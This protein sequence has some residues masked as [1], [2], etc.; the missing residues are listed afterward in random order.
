MSKWQLSWAA[1][2]W[3][4][5]SDVLRPSAMLIGKALPNTIKFVHGVIVRRY[6]KSANESGVS[7]P[8]PEEILL[9]PAH[10][11]LI[12][13]NDYAANQNIS[14]AKRLGLEP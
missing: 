8:S 3:K 11:T 6:G 14:F 13:Y 7:I 12:S 10:K 1:F 4:V 9:L 2:A 5:Y